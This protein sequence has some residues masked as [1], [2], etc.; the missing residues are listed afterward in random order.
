MDRQSYISTKPMDTV[1]KYLVGYM[2]DKEIHVSLVEGIIQMRPSFSYFDKLDTRKKAE[3]KHETE[4]DM[5][6]EEPKHVTVKFA[7]NETDKVR[8]AR[9]K[10]FNYLTK[11]SADEPW[12][13]TMWYP[14]D[15][16]QA[17]LERQKLFSI[18]SETTGHAL[19]L[20]SGEYIETLIPAERYYS[21]LD[22]LLPARVI[23]M[24]KLKSLSLSDQIENILKDGMT[25]VATVCS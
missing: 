24:A 19:S 17:Q 15:S 21:N 1:N 12:H 25:I 16:V 22:A 3:Q 8:K 5:D 7:R 11:K 13:E 18:S 10:S 14:K 9:E 2:Q 20:T 6:E 23:S 4:S